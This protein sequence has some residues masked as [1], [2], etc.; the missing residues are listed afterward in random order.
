MKLDWVWL[1]K[2]EEFIVVGYWIWRVISRSI[3]GIREKLGEKK[4]NVE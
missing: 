1:M 3:V 2:S 4:L